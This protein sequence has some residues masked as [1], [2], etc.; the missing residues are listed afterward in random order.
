MDKFQGSLD[1]ILLQEII[2]RIFRLFVDM[3]ENSKKSKGKIQGYNL[4]LGINHIS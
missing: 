3:N 2:R 1:M 4:R